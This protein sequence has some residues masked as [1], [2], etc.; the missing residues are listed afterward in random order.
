[1]PDHLCDPA[2]D[3]EK[4]RPD[5]KT[6][7]FAGHSKRQC[8]RGVYVITFTNRHLVT[9]L[10]TYL[11]PYVWHGT[12]DGV[13][14]RETVVTE[15]FQVLIFHSAEKNSILVYFVLNHTKNKNNNNNNNNLLLSQFK[16]YC[17]S[18][19]KQVANSPVPTEALF[20]GLSTTTG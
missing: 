9:Y 4:F 10:L 19:L 6:Y 2:V 1:M 18:E 20:S 12:K 5:P 8:I 17:G 15:I 13:P 3:S 11:L 14:E 16:T 7:L